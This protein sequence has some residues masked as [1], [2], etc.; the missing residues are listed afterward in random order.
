MTFKK[1]FS[2]FLILVVICS[3]S[4][5]AFAVDDYFY[6]D[7]NGV[8]YKDTENPLYWVQLSSYSFAKNMQTIYWK[9]MT[10]NSF[11]STISTSVDDLES[12][13]SDL[14]ND[15]FSITTTLGVQNGLLQSIGQYVDNLEGYLDGVEN[16]LTSIDTTVGIGNGVLSA[17]STKLSST[18]NATLTLTGGSE[19]S[20]PQYLNAIFRFSKSSYLPTKSFERGTSYSAPEYLNGIFNNT[21]VLS[22]INSS[23]SSI[24]SLIQ[25]GNTS[26]S[27]I[28]S[29]IQSGNTYLNSLVSSLSAVHSGTR[30]LESGTSYTTAQYLDYIAHRMRVLH[31]DSRTIEN[32]TD[33]SIPVLLDATYNKLNSGFTSLLTTI[34]VGNGS[35]ASIYS[36]L[37]D[38]EL[39]VVNNGVAL[40]RIKF[41]TAGLWGEYTSS[42]VIQAGDTVSVATLLMS[43]QALIRSLRNDINYVVSPSEGYTCGQL[44]YEIANNGIEIDMSDT[45][46]KL[47]RIIELL[48][49][50]TGDEGDDVQKD[51]VINWYRNLNFGDLELGDLALDLPT[52]DLSLVLPDTD[53]SSKD[54]PFDAIASNTASYFGGDLNTGGW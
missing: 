43:E 29:Y 4:V 12:Y 7:G 42:P 52:F 44:L 1:L 53:V 10:M 38:V 50:L 37:Y 5:S 47:D 18:Y 20:I 32:G 6:I 49:D 45:N 31:N 22:T 27:N 39:D 26:L 46:D 40:S 54:F 2:F 36:R 33:Y 30:T 16:G 35:L 9:L 24:S 51:S 11:L 14:N 28:A 17:I 34:G 48:E 13:L 21:S 41:D 25:S 15:V 23:V 3:L 19:Y 8:I